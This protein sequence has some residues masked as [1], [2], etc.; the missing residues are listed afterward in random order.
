VTV[1]LS[2]ARVADPLLLISEIRTGLGKKG[3]RLSIV[4]PISRVTPVKVAEASVS[5]INA[6]KSQSA[7]ASLRLTSASSVFLH[8]R[9]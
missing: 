1:R 5:A 7:S 2:I 3:D 9:R 4:G 8:H 6:A